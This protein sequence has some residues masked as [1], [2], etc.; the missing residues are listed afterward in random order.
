MPKDDSFPHRKLTATFSSTRCWYWD[1]ATLLFSRYAPTPGASTKPQARVNRQLSPWRIRYSQGTN[2]EGRITNGR[3]RARAAEPLA[4]P[5]PPSSPLRGPAR[6]S[7]GG[8]AR[9]RTGGVPLGGPAWHNLYVAPGRI[10]D[11]P[12]PIFP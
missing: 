8:G 4:P 6:T 2:G 3:A 7:G 12:R 5:R 1:H 11:R 10:A 9:A